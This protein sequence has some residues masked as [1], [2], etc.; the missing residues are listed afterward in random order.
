MTPKKHRSQQWWRM[1]WVQFMS[2]AE[3]AEAEGRT[4]GCV[5]SWLKAK[6]FSIR[7]PSSMCKRKPHPL[8]KLTEDQ[9]FE[10]KR[11]YEAGDRVV[12]LTKDYPVIY[13]RIWEIVHGNHRRLVWPD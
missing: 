7:R 3:I 12:D 9:I 8:Q 4:S 1:Y 13:A 5:A 11:R 6:G 2:S 10:I